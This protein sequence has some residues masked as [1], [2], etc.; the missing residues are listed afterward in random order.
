MAGGS[1]PYNRAVPADL[2]TPRGLR[3]P[4]QPP[5]GQAV[6][7]P[8]KSMAIRALVLAALCEEPVEVGPLPD[9]D[10][11]RATQAALAALETTGP[12][13]VGES[14]TLARFA[15]ALLAFRPARGTSR[16]A[17]EGTL[18]RRTSEPLC[19]ALERAGVGLGFRGEPGGFEV[20]VTPAEPPAELLLED[21]ASS[22]E[23]SALLIALAAAG[24]ERTLRV[25]GPIPS[26][27]YFAM[28]LRALA[29]FGVPVE[30]GGEDGERTFRLAGPPRRD[31]PVTVEPDASLAAVP[32]AAAALTGGELAVFS[33]RPGSPQGDVRIAR[34]LAAFGCRAFC[35]Q[36]GLRAGGAPTGGAELDLGDEPDLAPVLAAVAAA[37]AVRCG[38]P[39]RF[40]GLATLRRKES[41]RVD[42]I[43]EALRAVGLAVR[44]GADTLAV[45]PGGEPPMGDVVLDPRGDHRLAFLHAL[46]GL[47]HPAVFT[48]EPACVRKTW[49]SFWRDMEGLGFRIVVGG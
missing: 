4:E 36:D 20:E 13:P 6:V 45:E 41:D 34:H 11:V 17:P 14:G 47:V 37:A 26:R 42:G 29:G 7:P 30:E 8:S 46:L 35:D 15:L 43:A 21:P 22:Q 27:P 32:L 19:R 23:A 33:L 5:F 2:P 1:R 48:A 25:R 31:E 9:G 24:G 3:A 44:A 40:A 38:A 10:D 39:S 16:L 28:T 49:P 18:R 12:V